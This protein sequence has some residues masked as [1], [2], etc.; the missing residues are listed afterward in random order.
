MSI[1]VKHNLLTTQ[2]LLGYLNNE[3]F[4]IID[5]RPVDAFNGWKLE[6]ESRGGMEMTGFQ[7]SLE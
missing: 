1:N 7:P 6:G 4:K 2:E 5:I 3:E